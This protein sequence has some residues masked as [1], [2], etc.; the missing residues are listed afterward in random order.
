MQT[1]LD[2]TPN[3]VIPIIR[4]EI[5][6]RD[7]Y[8][9]ITTRGRETYQ[10]PYDNL[11]VRPG[12]NARTADNPGFSIESLQELARSI[13]HEGLQE[14][15]TID[16]IK[17][18]DKLIGIITKGERRWRSIGIIRVWIKDGKLSELF[19]GDAEKAIPTFDMVECF[20]N[21]SKITQKDR[22]MMMLLENMARVDLTPLEQAE[23]V[24]RLKAAGMS[25]AQIAKSVPGMSTM[26]VSLRLALASVSEEEKDLIREGKISATAAVKLL[27]E[28][29]DPTKR[30]EMINEAAESESGK[31]KI[32]DI[33]D[34]DTGE[35]LTEEEANNSLRDGDLTGASTSEP[36]DP[37][38][39]PSMKGSSPKAPPIPQR[40]PA[41]KT[42]DDGE[43]TDERITS[44]KSTTYDLVM[45]CIDLMKEID[46][47]TEE[48]QS[49]K[50]TTLIYNMDKTL[51]DLRIILKR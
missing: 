44:G 11:E 29:E 1:E 7:E 40:D 35:I 27:K 30:V 28:E 49:P 4:D 36:I 14:P 19:S 41:Q 42:K 39:D 26:M 50:L 10:F 48:K 47:E 43:D 34:E 13:F 45:R 21:T 20:I 17:R 38:D 24:A 46:L 12:H 15:I 31:L 37:K 22:D 23:A 33:V 51:A 16:V 6:S 2:I 3:T 9:K 25:Q 18:G 32:A 8:R 5:A